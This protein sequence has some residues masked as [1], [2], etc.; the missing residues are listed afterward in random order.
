MLLQN[1]IFFVQSYHLHLQYN[2]AADIRRVVKPVHGSMVELLIYILIPSSLGY[3]L[4]E[5]PWGP[6]LSIV[7]SFYIDIE[8]F[9]DIV[10]TKC[11]RFSQ[12]LYNILSD[13]N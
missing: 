9:G 3:F 2:Q 11:K 8:Y 1:A 5:V 6:L 4:R 7:S 12:H 13:I 10:F